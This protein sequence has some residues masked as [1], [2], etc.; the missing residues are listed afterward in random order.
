M[1]AVCLLALMTQHKVSSGQFVWISTWPRRERSG[2]AAVDPYG[3]AAALQ[4]RRHGHRRH[5]PQDRRGARLGPRP[6]QPRPLDVKDLYAWQANHSADRLTYPWS[7]AMVSCNGQ[8]Q[9]ADWDTAMAHI[10]EHSRICLPRTGRV[11]GLLHNRSAVLRE[12]TPWRQ[13]PGRHW[14]QPL[15]RTRCRPS[16]RATARAGKPSARFNRRISAH[17]RGKYTPHWSGVPSFHPATSA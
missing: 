9:P 3:V 16:L 17:L 13:S 4:R 5:R 8:L 12:V 14:H 7:A 6:G 1:V 15:R 2:R 10:V 11:D